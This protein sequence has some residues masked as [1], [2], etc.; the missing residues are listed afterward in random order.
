M[1]VK[2]LKYMDILLNNF[3]YFSYIYINNNS[4]KIFC[5]LNKKFIISNFFEN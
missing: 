3:F 1:Y 5:L 2:K 4:Y